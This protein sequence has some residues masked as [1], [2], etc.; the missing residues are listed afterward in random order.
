MK[1]FEMG[2]WPHYPRVNYGMLLISRVE[3]AGGRGDVQAR[4]GG[5]Y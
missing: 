3:R 5:N 2:F 1:V 4:E